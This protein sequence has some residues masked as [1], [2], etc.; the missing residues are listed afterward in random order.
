M[1]FRSVLTMRCFEKQRIELRK[2]RLFS[3]SVVTHFSLSCSKKNELNFTTF[4]LSTNI[5]NAYE[6]QVCTWNNPLLF[7][8]KNKNWK[9]QKLKKNLRKVNLNLLKLNKNQNQS[10]EKTI[11]V[12]SAQ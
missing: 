6:E 3:F 9:M 4:I 8:L 12:S 7:V 10:R 1:N 11:D 2:C 5:F